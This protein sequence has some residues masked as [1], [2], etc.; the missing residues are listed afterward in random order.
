MKVT[1][2]YLLGLIIDNTVQYV[3]FFF[4]F[5]VVKGGGRLFER[6]RLLTKIGLW[7]GANSRVGAYLKLNAKSSIYVNCTSVSR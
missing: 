2:I 3:R 1:S 4:K 5:C 6:G 7:R